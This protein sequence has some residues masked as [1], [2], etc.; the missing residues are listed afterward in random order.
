MTC[1]PGAAWR[2]PEIAGVFVDHRRT[3]LPL[4]EAQEELIR[5]LITRGGRSIGCFIDLGAGAGAFAEL[6]MEAHP[7]STCVLVDF[8]QPMIAAARQRLASKRDRWRYVE[9]DLASPRWRDALPANGG[10]DAAVSGFCIHHLP[11]ARKR[12]LY[13]EIF[14]LL[15]PGGLFLN[16]EHVSAEG[17]AEGMFAE[18]TL[19][20]LIEVEQQKEDSRPDDVV[21]REF[22]EADDED[23]LA[24]AETQCDWLRQIGFRQV[25]VFF[26][27]PEL[28]LFGGVREEV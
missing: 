19:R 28:A 2:K 18:D 15:A 24:S 21:E 8:S 17:L 13:A 4:L 23:I 16:W 14:E 5:R 26:K 1:A 25:D 3:L 20:R 22:R 6:V 9:A 10:F 11:D 7:E 12:E 27:L